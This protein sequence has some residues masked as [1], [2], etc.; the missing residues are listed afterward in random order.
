MSNKLVAKLSPGSQISKKAK[1]SNHTVNTLS[2]QKE[3]RQGVEASATIFLRQVCRNG[4]FR[5]KE[6]WAHI[7]HNDLIWVEVFGVWCSLKLHSS[8]MAGPKPTV[9]QK[10]II[11]PA[12][13]ICRFTHCLCYCVVATFNIS[14]WTDGRSADAEN[15]ELVSR[16][17]GA[18]WLTSFWN[19]QAGEIK[20][21]AQS[22]VMMDSTLY[23]YFAHHSLLQYFP[24]GISIISA[25]VCDFIASDSIEARMAIPSFLGQQGF[26]FQ[27]HHQFACWMYDYFT[28][29]FWQIC[30]VSFQT[31]IEKFLS[32]RLESHFLQ[33]EGRWVLKM[34]YVH[35]N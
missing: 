21:P 35:V 26:S 20:T 13:S 7:M 2:A 12:Y 16:T 9:L 14:Q 6:S 19:L 4:P 3:R 29:A 24:L 15:F 27:H 33:G 5:G 22:L 30:F 1:Y 25:R 11:L 34:I 28:A 23:I 10:C 32:N 17:L 18:A 8:S 31:T